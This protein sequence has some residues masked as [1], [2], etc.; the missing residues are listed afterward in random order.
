MNL[1]KITLFTTLLFAISGC[2]TTH[3]SR[4]LQSGNQ[5]ELR[6][7]QTRSFDTEDKNIVVRNVISTLQDLSFVIDKADADL[8]TVSATKLSGYK[9]RMTVT[10]RPQSGESVLVRAN[11]QYNLKPIENPNVYQD[12]FSVLSK[13]LFLSANSVQ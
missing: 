13:S 2:A 5:V 8:G 1:L 6:S 3:D 4:I 9:I 12:F 11:A 10:V 7:M